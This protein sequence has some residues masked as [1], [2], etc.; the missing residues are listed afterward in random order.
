MRSLYV[1][2]QGARVVR[3]G[4]RIR[5]LVGA[6]RMEAV[7]P[8][9]LAQCVVLGNV[10]ITTPAVRSLLAGGADVVFLTRG[11]RFLGRLS[12]GLSRNV[13]L[14]REQYRALA[15]PARALEL[16]SSVVAAKIEN[17]RRLLRRYQARRKDDLIAGAL[18]SLRR[19]GARVAAAN[20][21]D[22][23]RGLEGGAAAAYFG[24]WKQLV[25][26]EG[27][28]FEKR[29]RRPPP[30]PVNVLLSFGYTLLGNLLHSHVEAAGLDPYLGALHE[31]RYGRPSL[32]LDVIEELR[33][34][35]VDTAALRAINTRSI[36]P[37]DFT[38]LREERDTV[39]ARWEREDYTEDA[40]DERSEKRPRRD[41]L[42]SRAGVKKWL[43]AF[44]RRLDE[45]CH[46]PPRDLVM[47]L[48][49]IARAQ[50]YLL[51]RHLEGEGR[52]Q[53]FLSPR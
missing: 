52:Y 1:V 27:I 15:D 47:S 13:L 3:E 46:Y 12:G 30:D 34:V 4:E 19:F 36:T 44:E 7:R 2:E 50:V 43:A 49:D 51:A 17:Q 21:L 24:C 32:V 11:G 48:R 38:D 31:P 20:S 42:F 41:L 9:D 39:E 5:V 6:V 23:L 26:A 8:E 16:A 25:T 33:P 29:M 28:T 18:V 53:P 22:E 10:G 35:V 37:R 14:R 40:E 45:R